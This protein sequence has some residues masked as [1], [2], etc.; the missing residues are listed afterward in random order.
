MPRHDD[1]RFRRGS[2]AEWTSTNP[3]L[4][5]GEPGFES[6]TGKL[7]IGDGVHAWVDLG[8]VQ[9][10][11]GGGGGT[12]GD[13]TNVDDAADAP[14]AGQVL[15]WNNVGAATWVPLA[16]DSFNRPDGPLG[17]TELGAY[18]WVFFVTFLGEVV[19]NAVQYPGAANSVYAACIN[20]GAGK[21][22]QGI[23]IA[24]SN[25]AYAQV[26]GRIDLAADSW[27]NLYWNNL[28]NDLRFATRI[29]GVT[30]DVASFAAAGRGAIR[31]EIVGDECRG[32]LDG[33]LRLTYTITDARLRVGTSVGIAALGGNGGID[34]FQ[35]DVLTTAG[36]WQAGGFS[37]L[38]NQFGVTRFK[39]GGLTN[40]LYRAS[41]MTAIFQVPGGSVQYY[42]LL[43]MHP[44]GDDTA[45]SVYDPGGWL[46]TAP[47]VD[48]AW[49]GATLPAYTV[50]SL[51]S[52]YYA[53]NMRLEL[54]NPT[55]ADSA[56]LFFDQVG[57]YSTFTTRL[58]GDHPFRMNSWPILEGQRLSQAEYLTSGNFYL[59][60]AARVTPVLQVFSTTNARPVRNLEV[61]LTRLSS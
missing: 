39:N 41:D 55:A 15:T 18:T 12:L 26:C 7:K 6:N 31:M 37:T 8:Y 21:L 29:A 22:D 3:V 49:W 35:A 19:S 59:T 5:Q 27:M 53:W 16:T 20:L 1:I 43:N 48:S 13:L 2:A 61:A 14:N 58:Y 47:Y 4:D 17:T 23:Q 25:D 11:G 54:S 28:T 38:T 24:S 10:T 32:Y 40:P 44:E 56:D 50:L 36:E 30:T 57:D 46:N 60:Q 45:S 51:P 33:I 34:D 52:G 9:G 42:S